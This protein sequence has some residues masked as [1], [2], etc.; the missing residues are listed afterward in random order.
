MLEV[1]R[2][3]RQWEDAFNVEN[4]PSNVLDRAW[5]VRFG[6]FS[7]TKN[8]QNCM[9]FSSLITLS[10]FFKGY[11]SPKDAVDQALLY[12]D[13]IIKKCC[14]PINRLNQAA[15]KNVLPGN[16][17]IRELDNSNDNAAVLEI[18]FNCEII[19]DVCEG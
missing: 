11:R 13:I 16:I 12:T 9:N 3:F 1:G 15:I 14:S 6:P 10:V 2:D 7:F 5:H 17:D 4:I 19:L 8:A 18:Q